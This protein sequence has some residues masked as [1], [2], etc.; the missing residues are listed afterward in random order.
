MIDTLILLTDGSVRTPLKI[1]CGAY[2]ALSKN[3]L[4]A[5]QHTASVKVKRFEDTSS[6]KLELQT[7]LWALS[8]I[9]G[10]SK[11]IVVYTDAQSIIELPGRRARLEQNDYRTRKNKH[12]NNH[13]LYRK[14]FKLMDQL[15]CDLI[16]VKGHQPS[17]QKNNIDKL[18]TLVD[19]ASRKALKEIQDLT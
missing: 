12:L 14:F 17:A 19:R 15:D 16:K 6:S 5:G 4:S 7:L 9:R 18:F 10:T 13:E 1:G 2:L 3:E 11:K 8:E